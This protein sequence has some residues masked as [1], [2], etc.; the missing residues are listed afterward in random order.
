MAKKPDLMSLQGEWLAAKLTNGVAGAYFEMGNTPEANIGIT[1]ETVDHFTAKDG[2]R[3][4]D[5]VLRKATGV[6]G[7]MT[8]EEINKQNKNIVFSG[9]TSSVASSTIADE[10]LGVVVAGQIINL[11]KRNLSN[12]VFKAG[13]G[14][15]DASTYTL[16]PVFGT[17][18]FN[19]AP[20]EAV[21]WSATAGA[22][23]RTAIANSLGNEYALLFKGID[24]YSG[25]K[26]VVELWR[27][28]FS[29]ETEFALINEE[30]A[31]F[32]LEFECLAD[33]TK[34]TDPQLGSFGIVEQFKIVA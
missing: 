34:A 32:D 19:T 33:A 24:T 21:S 17:V 30:F 1:T 22:V 28:Q 18:V 7:K 14:A 10:V 27:V 20:S 26:L 8:A 13:S 23:E 15:V 16:D 3:A 12:V 11:G 9:N 31:S 29:P 25:D 4:K 6:T 2:T 5:A